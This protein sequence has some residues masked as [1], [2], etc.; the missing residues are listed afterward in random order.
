MNLNNYTNIFCFCC[1]YILR[2]TLVCRAV[3]TQASAKD[4][5]VLTIVSN[6]YSNKK[7]KKK[8]LKPISSIKSKK[9]QILASKILWQL[10][11]VAK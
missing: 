6:C 11:I 4:L 9:I 2:A 7:H 5:F 1:A 10:N 3:G 8:H